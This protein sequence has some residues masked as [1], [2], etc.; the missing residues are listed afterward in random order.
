MTVAARQDR[1]PGD[2]RQVAAS[3]TLTGS[4]NHYLRAKGSHIRKDNHALAKRALT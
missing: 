4:P 1:P 2:A 3:L